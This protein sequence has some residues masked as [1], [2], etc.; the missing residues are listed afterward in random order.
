LVVRSLHVHVSRRKPRLIPRV[1]FRLRFL[2]SIISSTVGWAGRW[3]VHQA[4][5]AP[6][7]ANRK[8]HVP[9]PSPVRQRRAKV[10]RGTTI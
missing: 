5:I 4:L 7:H 1:V 8:T 6:C 9:H 10:A 2:W 3:A